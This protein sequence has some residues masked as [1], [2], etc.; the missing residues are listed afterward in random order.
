[1]SPSNTLPNEMFVHSSTKRC[2]QKK[3]WNG[4]VCICFIDGTNVAK[5]ALKETK[6]NPLINL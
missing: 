4:D 1:M 2:Y 6:D 5:I 3:L